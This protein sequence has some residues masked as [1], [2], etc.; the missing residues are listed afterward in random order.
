MQVVLC[1]RCDRGNRYCSRTCSRQARDAARC[2][3][4]SRYQRS[5]RGRAAHAERMRRWRQRAAA[6]QDHGANADA[7][8]QKVTHQGCPPGPPTAPL[9]TWTQDS[10]IASAAQEVTPPQ[11]GATTTCATVS[12]HCQR[13]AARL[14]GW[15][16]Q[17]FVR[18]AVRPARAVASA[19]PRG[20]RRRD[21]LP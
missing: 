5:R 3:A 18:H 15:L 2:E 4:A 13:C 12:M 16:R 17:G 20:G 21:H 10:T 19:A 9:A 11:C 1:S 7:E 6:C 14:P 8:S